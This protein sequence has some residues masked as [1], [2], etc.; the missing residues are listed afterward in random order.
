[1]CYS[2]HNNTW[3]YQLVCRYADIFSI[4]VILFLCYNL[5]LHNEVIEESTMSSSTLLIKKYKARCYMQY[6]NK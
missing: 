5:V 1:M 6:Q 4:L 3:S 2:S